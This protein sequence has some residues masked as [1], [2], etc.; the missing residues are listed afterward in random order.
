MV[1]VAQSR[2]AANVLWGTG[3]ADSWKSLGLF[4]L[5]R[6]MLAGLFMVLYLSRTGPRLLGQHSAQLFQ[7]S[8]LTYLGLAL[9]G[10]VL[11]LLRRPGFQVQVYLQGATDIVAIT[12]MMHASGGIIS[13]LGM[14]I[15][16][17]LAIAGLVAAGQTALVLAA[18]ATLAILSEQVYAHLQASFYTTAYTQAGILGLTFFATA[19]LAAVLSRRIRASE[20]VA[21]QRGVDLANLARLNEYIIQHMECGIV[22]VDGD[23]QIR[24]MNQSAWHLLGSPQAASG[25]TLGAVSRELTEQLQSWRTEKGFVPRL[26]NAAGARNQVAPRFEPLGG[27]G[28]AGTLVSLEDA[29]SMTKRAQQLK[30]AALGK[31]TAS[32]AHE[33]RNPLGAVSHAAQ[34]LSE[35]EEL[36]AGDRR[37]TEIIL[38]QCGRMNAV[39]QNVLQL[40][41]RDPARVETI[42]LEPWLQ[43]FVEEFERIE[44]VPQGDLHCAASSPELT[45]TVDPSQLRQVLANLCQNGLRHS[46]DT[47]GRPKVEIVGGGSR[48]GRAVTIDVI[49]HGLGVDPAIVQDIFDPFFTTEPRGTG[50]GLYIARELCIGNGGSLEY[51]PVRTGGSCFRITLASAHSQVA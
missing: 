25:V 11:A 16:T 9:L 18:M 19:F 44:R 27:V 34:L 2:N 41:R 35:D 48:D 33:M 40:S 32:I 31:L 45:A 14:L 28:A 21:K 43:S 36:P 12:L 50:L 6:L 7:V 38:Q 23:N 30:L 3:D 20:A 51:I 13:G 10:L 5:Y 24:L 15:V 39:V 8:C 47:T 1:A 46:A 22:V 26:F 42:R 4:A 37:L 29:S 49:D 17:T